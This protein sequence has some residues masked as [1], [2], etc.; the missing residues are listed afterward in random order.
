MQGVYS[1]DW[2][3]VLN[4]GWLKSCVVCVSVYVMLYRLDLRDIR[5]VCKVGGTIDDS[6]LV[7]GCVFDQKV[8][9]HTCHSGLSHC[10]TL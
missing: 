7:D 3:S 8:G 6:E 5:V 9:P 2:H 4:T 1:K 10:R